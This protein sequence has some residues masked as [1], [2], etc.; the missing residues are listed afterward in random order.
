MD[1]VVEV[2]DVEGWDGSSSVEDCP[3]PSAQSVSSS[4]V[5]VLQQEIIASRVRNT[6]L[7]LRPLP[8][9]VGLPGMP[10]GICWLRPFGR[11]R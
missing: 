9:L 2:P 10:S 4:H 3:L 7:P 1:D 11:L 5:E 6:G 8:S